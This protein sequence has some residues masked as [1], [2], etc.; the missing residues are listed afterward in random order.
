MS[1]KYHISE[2]GIPRKC[3]ARL[4]NCP[5]GDDDNHYS[6]Y[7]IAQKAYEAYASRS[8]GTF[9]PTRNKFPV[10]DK[11]LLAAQRKLDRAHDR[12]LAQ[13]LRNEFEMI[14]EM[15]QAVDTVYA[16]SEAENLR[17]IMDYRAVSLAWNAEQSLKKLEELKKFGHRLTEE[18]DA[19]EKS[20]GSLAKELRKVS[21]A[22]NRS[23][24]KLTPVDRALAKKEERRGYSYVPVTEER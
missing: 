16:R 1:S 24:T 13:S 22:I 3:T 19:I 21:R 6:S 18:A 5:L 4:G 10:G 12:K 17:S 23:V 11:E 9:S 2:D 7:A 20:Y 14:A 8:M 15:L